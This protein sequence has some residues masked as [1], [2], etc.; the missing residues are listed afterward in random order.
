VCLLGA[1]DAALAGDPYAQRCLREQVV[2]QL[3]AELHTEAGTLRWLTVWNDV[4]GRTVGEVR[5]LLRRTAERLEAGP[6]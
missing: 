6:R 1:V 2:A 5:E 3:R 4:P